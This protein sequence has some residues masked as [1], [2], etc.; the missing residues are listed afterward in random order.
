MKHRA[1]ASVQGVELFDDVRDRVTAQLESL[2]PALNAVDPT[3]AGALDTSRQ[4]VMHQVEALRTKY[5]N[6]EARRNETLERH[7]DAVANSVY[8][9]KKLQERVV[10]ITSFVMRYGLE[11]VGRLEQELSLDSR[12]HQVIEI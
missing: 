5:V 6:A 4:K 3:L 2:R 10:N 11:F 1:V 7:L 8:P 9:E 12:E